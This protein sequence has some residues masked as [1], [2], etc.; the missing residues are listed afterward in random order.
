MLT[1][2]DINLGKHPLENKSKFLMQSIKLPNMN[3]FPKTFENVEKFAPF[4]LQQIKT[5]QTIISE[6]K[7]YY[8]SYCPEKYIKYMCFDKLLMIDI[9]NNEIDIDSHFDNQKDYTWAIYKSRRGYHIFCIS[10]EFEYYDTSTIDLM[11]KNHCD[12]YYSCFSFLRGFCVRL[13][14]KINEE[15]PIYNFLGIY[16]NKSLINKKLLHLAQLH[17]EFSNQ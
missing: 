15:L 3:L 1:I 9:D 6:T 4:L 7:D 16:G 2:T 17:F 11:L 5:Q 14:P 13:S 8:I 10:Q 12:F